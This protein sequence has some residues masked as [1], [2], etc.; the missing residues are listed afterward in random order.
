M[1]IEIETLD[2]KKMEFALDEVG[3][4]YPSDDVIYFNGTP[5]KLSTAQ[6]VKTVRQLEDEERLNYLEASIPF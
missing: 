6:P 4:C 2:G 1:F 5:C 3:S